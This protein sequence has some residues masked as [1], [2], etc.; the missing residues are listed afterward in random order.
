MATTDKRGLPHAAVAGE[1][2]QIPDEKLAV[3]A[4]FC[5][6]T[7]MEEEAMMNGYAPEHLIVAPTVIRGHGG[8][9]R[10]HAG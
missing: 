8:K 4:W 2:V 7:I 6:G 5:P 10:E 9:P 1:F 3:S